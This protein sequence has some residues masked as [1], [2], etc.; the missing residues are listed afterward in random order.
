MNEQQILLAQVNDYQTQLERMYHIHRESLS[1][2]E[3]LE[4]EVDELQFKL[5][6]AEEYNF[7]LETSITNAY[8]TIK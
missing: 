8:R 2:I 4:A 6:K 5:D 1:K 7:D 3:K